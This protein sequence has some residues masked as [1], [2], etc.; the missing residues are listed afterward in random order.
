MCLYT[1]N[2]TIEKYFHIDLD[3]IKGKKQQQ[4]AMAI[5]LSWK[6]FEKLFNT[7]YQ[8]YLYWVF[9][10]IYII[11]KSIMEDLWKAYVKT[12]EMS[13]FLCSMTKEEK[14]EN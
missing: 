6:L 13:F 4:L 8:V 11:Y 2:N 1:F 14:G 7:I 10:H 3:T 9:K 5:P 12:C